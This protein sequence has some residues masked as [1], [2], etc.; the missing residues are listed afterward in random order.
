[1]SLGVVGRES[2]LAEVERFID[3]ADQGFAVLVLEGEA[4]IGK[5]TL[6]R[7]AR[8]LAEE[9]GALVLR[10]RPSAAEAKFSFA[11]VADLLSVVDEEAF[12]ALPEPQRAALEVALLRA[13]PP[14]RSP[15]SR[16]VSAAFLTLA[17]GLA[18]EQQVLLAIDDWQWLD[19]ASRRVIEFAA[20]RL[21]SERVR[22]LCAVR[23][24]VAAPLLGGA[25]AEERGRRVVLKSQ[26]L[27]ALGRIVADRLGQSLPRPVL[28]RIVRLSGGNPFYTLEV[29]RLVIE[30]GAE[31]VPGSELPV[32]D[33]LRRLS[34][35]RIRR[36]PEAAREAVL[37]AAV[38]SVRTAKR[39]MSAHL[40]RPK[41]RGS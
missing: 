22:L 9:R 20:R 26:S 36:L 21:E 35:S 7:E 37:L 10:C 6:W 5:T 1:M 34:A 3:A 4:G 29:A 30:S 19:A 40:G 25:L 41:T 38:L 16:A 39:W 11:G 28:V 8:R 31:R 17:R 18:D 15:F 2:E 14:T 32:P 24:P 23:S 33:D 12:A 27:A 13:A